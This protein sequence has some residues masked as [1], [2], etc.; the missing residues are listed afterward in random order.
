MHSEIVDVNTLN[1]YIEVVQDFELY[2]R[3]NPA[4][5]SVNL[6]QNNLTKKLE[7]IAIAKEVDASARQDTTLEKDTVSEEIAK[8]YLLD[9]NGEVIMTATLN[10]K[11]SFNFGKIIIK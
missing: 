10:E 1:T 8:L 3:R 11:G 2:A 7:E 6:I 5:D 9:E 4:I